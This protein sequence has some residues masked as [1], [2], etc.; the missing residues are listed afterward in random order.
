MNAITR[1]IG[2][3][4]ELKPHRFSVQDMYAMIAAGVLEE[5]GR[6]ELIEGALIEMPADGPR[7]KQLSSDLTFWLARQL[8]PNRYTVVP[9]ATLR[10]SDFDAPSPDWCVSPAAIALDDLRGADALL[11]I[12]QSDSSL[13]RDLGWKA[14]LYARYGVRDYWVIDVERREI[15]VHR[16]PSVDGFGFRKRF[17]AAEAVDALLIPGLAL[18]LSRLG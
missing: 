16:D 13:R 15:H 14:A 6:E 11:V 4:D 3:T 1:T 12:E 7:H 17:S 5:G 10:L 8:D 2:Q 18:Q 9:N